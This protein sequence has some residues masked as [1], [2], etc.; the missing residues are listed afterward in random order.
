MEI[1]QRIANHLTKLEK[2]MTDSHEGIPK[3]NK[4]IVNYIKDLRTSVLRWCRNGRYSHD[5]NLTEKSARALDL[6]I[7][8]MLKCQ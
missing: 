2:R 6:T 4:R 8:T 1:R 7:L 3:V 5:K